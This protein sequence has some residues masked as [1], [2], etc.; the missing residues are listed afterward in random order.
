MRRTILGC[1]V[2]KTRRLIGKQMVICTVALVLAFCENIWCMCIRTKENS[3]LYF[4]L[5]VVADVIAAW[6]TIY[7]ITT[8][9]MPRKKYMRIFLKEGQALS[10]IVEQVSAK[11]ERYAR[12]D[13]RPIRISGHICFLVENGHISLKEGQYVS[14]ETV[15]GIIKDVVI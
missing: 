12:M 11:T 9:I 14:V 6:I 15:D 1:S 13:C 7:C 3:G 4:A 10:G 8:G 2:K 5:I